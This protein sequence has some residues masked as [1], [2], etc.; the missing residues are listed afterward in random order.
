MRLLLAIGAKRSGAWP[1]I[2]KPVQKEERLLVKG[3]DSR[4]LTVVKAVVVRQQH[5]DP[6]VQGVERPDM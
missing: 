6:H 4:A 2:A 3:P 5:P 1:A